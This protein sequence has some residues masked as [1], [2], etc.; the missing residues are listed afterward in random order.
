MLRFSLGWLGEKQRRATLRPNREAIH[1]FIL[2]FKWCNMLIMSH[3][4][5][6]SLYSFKVTTCINQISFADVFID[7]FDLQALSH[8]TALPPLSMPFVWRH[9]TKHPTPSRKWIPSFVIL[10]EMFPLLLLRSGEFPDMLRYSCC[11][12][13]CLVLVDIRISK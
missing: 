11:S 2:S 13:M 9:G 7:I 10:G 3:Q 5:H 12:W 1:P 4:A 6:C 8:P